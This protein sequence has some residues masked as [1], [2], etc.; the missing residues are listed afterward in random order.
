MVATYRKRLFK[1][2]SS[3]R[4]CLAAIG[5]LRSSDRGAA[6][7]SCGRCYKRGR[8]HQPRCSIA[9]VDGGSGRITQ[10]HPLPQGWWRKGCVETGSGEQSAG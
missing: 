8:S 7:G 6:V 5:V 10:Q 1:M 2:S 9:R 3:L 4:P